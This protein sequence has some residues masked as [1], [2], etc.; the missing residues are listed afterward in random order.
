MI[1]TMDQMSPLFGELNDRL[2]Y[3]KSSMETTNVINEI[4]EMDDLLYVVQRMLNIINKQQQTILAMK[5]QIKSLEITKTIMNDHAINDKLDIIIGGESIN[6]KIIGIQEHLKWISKIQYHHTELLEKLEAQQY[7]YKRSVSTKK[8]LL[9]FSNKDKQTEDVSNQ[10]QKDRKKEKENEKGIRLN[11][12]RVNFKNVLELK[13]TKKASSY[14]VTKPLR[15]LI[16]NE[17]AS[18]SNSLKK[19]FLNKYQKNFDRTVKNAIEE[20][21][22]RRPH[23]KGESSIPTKSKPNANVYIPPT[24]KADANV[25]IPPTSKAVARLKIRKSKYSFK[26]DYIEK[27]NHDLHISSINDEFCGWS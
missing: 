26:H 3:V 6:K 14:P 21:N 20:D 11:P 8:N 16:E 13:Q 17:T 24:S 10:R 18:I 27:M 1:A 19:I 2:S 15:R 5:S 4:P 23:K 12:R 22:K 25:Y 9:N 7:A